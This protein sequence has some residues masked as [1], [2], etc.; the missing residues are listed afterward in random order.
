MAQAPLPVLN[1]VVKLTPDR[2]PGH[3]AP[4]F[5]F[6]ESESVNVFGVREKETQ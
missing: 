4:P 2:N 3:R 1:S 5:Y 6:G